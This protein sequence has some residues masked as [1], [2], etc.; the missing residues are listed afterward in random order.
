MKKHAIA[1][2]LALSLL[3]P[4]AAARAAGPFHDVPPNAGYAPAVAWCAENGLMNGMADGIF[5][6]DGSMTRAMLATVLYRQAGQPAVTDGPGFDDVQPGMWYFNAIT[7]V[8]EAGLLRGYGDGI[9]APDAPVSKEMLDVVMARQKGLSPAWTGAPELAKRSEAAV[10]FYKAYAGPIAFLPNDPDPLE[11]RKVTLN[12]GYEMPILGLGTWTQDDSTAENSVYEALKA[13]CRLIDTAQYYGNEAGVGAGVRKAI[14]EGI[15]KR[16][17]VFVTTKVMPANYQDA[18]ASIA[19]SNERLGLGYIDLMLVHQPGSHDKETYAALEQAVKD[20]TVRSIG[21][22]NY[23][24]AEAFEQVLSAAEIMPAV[25][26][27][28]NHI[29]YQNTAFQEYLAQF[30][31]VLESYYPFGGRGHTQDSMGHAVIQAIAE[32]YGKTAAQ[33]I[34]RWHLQAG[35]VAIPGSSD[36]GHIRENLDVFDFSLTKEEMAQIAALDTQQRYENW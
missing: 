14:D 21:I 5:E 25:V 3:L 22:S 13:G 15:V 11:L 16:E 32:K 28:E 31:T 17:E 18:A 24:T 30:G 20:G 4:S 19:G 9:F 6:P 27:N 29:F 23:Y 35:Y 2:L 1:F 33:V 10:A 26:Q 34:L 36:P 12:S 8:A 7:W